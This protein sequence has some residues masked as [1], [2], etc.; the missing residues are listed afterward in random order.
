MILINL[1]PVNVGGNESI[2]DKKQFMGFFL[3][4][5]VIGGIAFAIP[6]SVS[7][8]LLSDKDTILAQI[9]EKKRK[10]SEI[11]KQK[12]QLQKLKVTFV[13]VQG[14]S[15]EIL[16][17]AQNRKALIQVM[18]Q[19]QT[20]HLP[21]TWI[22]NLEANE[23]K[24]LFSGYASDHFLIAEY[25]AKLKTYTPESIAII[26]D[27][28]QYTPSLDGTSSTSAEPAQKNITLKEFSK[29]L[30]YF[31]SI[32]LKKSSAEEINNNPYQKFDIEI[33]LG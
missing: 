9:S 19:L 14:R 25:M 11:E 21:K 2:I 12:Q 7:L 15:A 32:R 31:R 16:Q 8:Y 22:D 28:R 13:D 17:L 30:L 10:I 18:D 5:L 27:Y 6:Y 4:I 29:K 20:F 1:K 33:D 26:E 23:N 3:V 24:V